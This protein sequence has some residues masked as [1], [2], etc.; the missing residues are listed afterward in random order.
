MKR[1]LWLVC[2]LVPLTATAAVSKS[3]AAH[4]SK[5]TAAQIIARNVQARGGL[6]AWRAVD[7][8]T[9]SGKLDAGSTK[10]PQLPFV[11]RMKR[12]HKSR[13]EIRFEDRTAVQVYDGKQGWKVRPFLGR[14][15]V[16]PFTGTE[17]REAADWQELDGP[18][19]DYARKG[20]KVE[21]QGIETVEGHK[22]YKLRLA[23]KDGTERHVWIDAAK[24][25]ELKIDGQPRTMDGKL[26]QVVVYYRDY[27]AEKG[28]NM[29]HVFETVIEG[30]KKSYKMHVEQVAVN[31]PMDDTL[32]AKPQLAVVRSAYR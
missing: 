25:L 6:K 14:N 3:Q 20:T 22:A 24:F 31:Q 17:A 27:R 2:F 8:L 29:P 21:L 9:L 1:F 16:E 18:L 23:M 32:F 15:E 11:M 5:L 13:L 10:N 7:T 30:G 19:V 28:L 12:Q 4:G 26:R